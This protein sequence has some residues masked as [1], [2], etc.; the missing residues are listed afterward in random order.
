MEFTTYLTDGLVE[1][2]QRLVRNYSGDCQAESLAIM[3][4]GI[5]GVVQEV[6]KCVTGEW[7]EKQDG[8]YP[9]DTD[10]CECGEQARYVRQREAV[11]ITL[12]GRVR[13]RRA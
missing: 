6:A 2:A 3:E 11:S 7:L 13:Y 5:Q 9:A 8:Q 10:G 1:A 4:Q 12:H